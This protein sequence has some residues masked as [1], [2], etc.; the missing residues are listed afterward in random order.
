VPLLSPT[1]GEEL[2]INELETIESAIRFACGRATL[3]DA[4]AEDFASEVKLRLIE[5]EYAVLRR[6]EGRAKFRTFI[7]IVIH[8]M[9]L[10]RRIQQWGKWRS[11]AEAKRLGPVAV[12]LETMINRDGRSLEEAF[13]HCQ[14]LDPQVTIGTLKELAGRLPE[15]TKRPRPVDVDTVGN[16]LRVDGDTVSEAAL[17]AERK[18]AAAAAGEIIRATIA[19]FA[20]E[21]QLLVRLHFG[22][23]MNVAEIARTQQLDQQPLYRRLKRCLFELRQRLEEAGISAVTA[24]EIAEMRT[25]DLDLGLDEK[26]EEACPSKSDGTSREKRGG[27][28]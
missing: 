8:R 7:D 18:V 14:K 25:S 15:R 16:E 27:S 2:F 19:E 10:D 22:A 6:Y 24:L 11:S 1:E 3:T 21:D 4:E 20:Q 23:G 13:P 28:R 9:L 26:T 17:D 12:E 5:N